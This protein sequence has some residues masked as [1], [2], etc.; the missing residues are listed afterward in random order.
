MLRNRNRIIIAVFLMWAFLIT[1]R[2]FYYTVY[3]RDH[4]LE[5]G[6][7]HAWRSGVIPA[8]RGRI[9]DKN[10]QPLAWTQRYYDLVIDIYP[11]LCRANTKLVGELRS[12]ISGL[13]PDDKREKYA[14]KN[15]TPSEIL[16]LKD[17]LMKYQG[18][19]IVPRMER[20]YVDYPEVRKVVGSVDSNEGC[21]FGVKGAE[22]KFEHE[23]RGIDGVYQVMLDRN[24]NWIPG[25]WKLKTEM[26]PGSDVK[27][28]YSLEEIISMNKDEQGKKF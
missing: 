27:L 13:I 28:E 14:K 10:G 2:L 24:R 19:K 15:L 8:A 11:D 25:T 7:K 5:E 18:V 23:L 22:Q 1:C 3:S 21:F 6:N 4:Y 12:R 9:L 26:R 17:Y 20:Q 16:V